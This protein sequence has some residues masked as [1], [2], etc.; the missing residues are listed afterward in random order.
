MPKG[1][2]GLHQ[3]SVDRAAE[4]DATRGFL[5]FEGPNGELMRTPYRAALAAQPA[6]PPA[7]TREKAA[8]QLRVAIADLPRDDDAIF[9]FVW[10]LLAR[11]VT[12]PSAIAA[13]PTPTEPDR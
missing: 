13:H 3:T 12:I 4:L 1:H 5:V 6:D 2:E 7:T 8:A 9:D 11:K 10:D